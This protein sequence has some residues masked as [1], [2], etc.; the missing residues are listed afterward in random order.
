MI[1]KVQGS[2]RVLVR[3]SVTDHGVGI[4]PSVLASLSDPGSRRALPGTEGELGTG[5][6]LKF[7]REF[8]ALHDSQLDVDAADPKGTTFSFLLARAPHRRR[9][10][11]R[12]SAPPGKRRHSTDAEK[13]REK[14]QRDGKRHGSVC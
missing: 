5:L 2:G 9:S 4:D 14:K 7:C 13:N 6:G 3:V 12:L 8:L 1:I 10:G 11:R